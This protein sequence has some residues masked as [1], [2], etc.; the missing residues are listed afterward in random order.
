[1]KKLSIEVGTRVYRDVTYKLEE[2]DG[3]VRIHMTYAGR[4]VGPL[5]LYHPVVADNE[6]RA[7]EFVH[8]WARWCYDDEKTKK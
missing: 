5:E 4:D 3:G 2:I 6:P 7:E 8:M 1:M